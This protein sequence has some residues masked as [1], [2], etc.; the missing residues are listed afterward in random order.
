MPHA[1]HTHKTYR[2]P[3]QIL[4]ASFC[5]VFI[6]KFLNKNVQYISICNIYPI[7]IF[8]S[9]QDMHIQRSHNERQ[10]GSFGQFP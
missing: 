1:L 9:S 3:V 6:Y 10:N 4:K 7:Y 8:T 5:T 2:L